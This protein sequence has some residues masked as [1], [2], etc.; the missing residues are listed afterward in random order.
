MAIMTKRERVLRAARLEE[1]DRVPVFDVLQNQTVI[2]HYAGQKLTA[3][4]NETQ[5][6]EV[7]G[8]EAC[9]GMVVVLRGGPGDL[10]CCEAP[11]TL[12][13]AAGVET[14]PDDPGLMNPPPMEYNLN[15]PVKTAIAFM[16]K[17]IANKTYYFGVRTLKNPLDFWVYREIIAEVQPDVII[18]V[19]TAYGG[20]AFALAHILDLLGK[21]RII[22]L[23]HQH[24]TVPQLV[25]EHPRITLFTGEACQS[26][27]RVSETIRPGETVLVIEDSSH[28]YENT[29][30]V[31][32]T[33]GPLVTPGS[34]LIVEDSNCHHG[35]DVGPFPGPYEAI[36]H[37]L[38]ETDAFEVDRSRESFFITWNPRGYLRRV[39]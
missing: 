6:Q 35:V 15:M 33:Y 14:E 20:G 12:V 18:E 38:R 23:D 4:R 32:R 24:D 8:C 26:F 22:S 27:S 30:A 11:M 25:K 9:G 17:R 34:Y 29:L 39:G 10:R 19:G 7:Y 31:L 37:F 1:T 5:R 13:K 16:Q 2:E 21:G 36:D 3:A 28:S